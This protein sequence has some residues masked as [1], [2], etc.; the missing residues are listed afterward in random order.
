VGTRPLYRP[1]QP[2]RANV[3][4]ATSRKPVY[5]VGCPGDPEACNLVRRRL[6]AEDT[7]RMSMRAA[8]HMLGSTYGRHWWHRYCPTRHRMQVLP[9][10]EAHRDRSSCNM[11]FS[12]RETSQSHYLPFSRATY[13]ASN[14]LISMAEYGKTPIKP[15]W[16]GSA[17]VRAHSP[18]SLVIAHCQ[19]PIIRANTARFPHRSSRISER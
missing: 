12:C 8:I 18:C 15:S 13:N 16:E 11:R 10:L 6:M 14:V 17:S 7:N 9:G 3:W 5:T 2:S 1:C 19:S 4:F